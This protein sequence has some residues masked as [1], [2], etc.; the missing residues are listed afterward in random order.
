MIMIVSL[1]LLCLSSQKQTQTGGANI[2]NTVLFKNIN[3]DTKDYKNAIL[4]ESNIVF[5]FKNTF[6]LNININTGYNA[7]SMPKFYLDLCSSDYKDDYILRINSICPDVNGIININLKGINVVSSGSYINNISKTLNS[8]ILNSKILNSK[9]TNLY[10]KCTSMNLADIR[11]LDYQ[12]IFFNSYSITIKSMALPKNINYYNSLLMTS[13]VLPPK[14]PLII[15]SKTPNALATSSIAH[16]NK[17][18]IIIG[19]AS[20]IS[21][22]FIVCLLHI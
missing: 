7:I 19:T 8:K 12:P 17:N 4:A 16:D 11:S 9:I 10:I 5:N 13:V 2:D 14:T 21:I 3:Y 6:D 20:I 15:T 1:V 22:I 18:M